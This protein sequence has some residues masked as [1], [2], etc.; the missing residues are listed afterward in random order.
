MRIEKF[1]SGHAAPQGTKLRGGK[2]SE[3]QFRMHWSQRD[4]VR[5]FLARDCANTFL[6]GG[7]AVSPKYVQIHK[8]GT[9][10]PGV[11]YRT[12]D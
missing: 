10:T 8:P 5:N 11:V 1:A 3:K 2:N 7:D 12:A 4:L 6:G 9:Q